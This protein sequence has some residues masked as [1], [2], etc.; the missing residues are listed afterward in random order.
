M[1]H[2]KAPLSNSLLARFA[3]WQRFTFLIGQTVVMDREIV[4]QDAR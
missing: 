4:E 2:D 1:M 3:V